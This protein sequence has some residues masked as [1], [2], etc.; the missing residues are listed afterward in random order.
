[1]PI[2]TGEKTQQLSRDEQPQPQP[3]AAPATRSPRHYLD[4]VG[5]SHNGSSSSNSRQDAAARAGLPF[6]EFFLHTDHGFPTSEE[7]LI[8]DGGY[9]TAPATAAYSPVTTANNSVSSSP[10]TT[11][12]ATSPPS[13]AYSFSGLSDIGTSSFP[14]TPRNESHADRRRRN[15]LASA[16]FRERKRGNVSRQAVVLGAA[17]VT[18]FREK[19]TAV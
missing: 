4:L 14:A 12:G 13:R 2:D 17:L 11:G 15:T 19:C 5:E 10:A 8:L 9:P 6:A 1:M 18:L 7:L 3:D 16:R